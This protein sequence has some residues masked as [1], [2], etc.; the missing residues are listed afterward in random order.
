MV[1]CFLFI[2]VTQA[3]KNVFK[4]K[5]L[6]AT[7]KK[8][9]DSAIITVLVSGDTYFTNEKGEFEI[10]DLFHSSVIITQ[11]GYESL[12]VKL[13]KDVQTLYL[14]PSL[15]QLKEIVV[16]RSKNIN[17]IDVRNLTGSVVTVD[18]SKLSE[19]SELDMA[20]LLQGQVPG[21]TVNYSGEL[22][23]KPEIRLRGN[24]SF[25][26]KGTANEPLFV[27]DGIIISTETFLTL[28]PNDFSSI[29][30]LKDAPATA[31]YGIKA[32]NGVIE[33]TSKRGFNGKATI[34]YSMKQG[35][36]MRGERP[37]EMMGTNEKLA[38]EEKIGV[39]GRPGFDYSQANIRKLFANS[40]LLQQ[41]LE[42]GAFKLDSLR[43]Y[44]T[45]WFKEL[46][47]P[48]HFQ[49]HNLSIRGGTEKSAYFYSV[50]YSKQGGRIP[51]NDINHVT[52]RAN[53]DYTIAPTFQ[54]SLNNSFGVS[55]TNTENGMTNDPT[56]LAFNLNPYET[57]ETKQLISYPRQSYSDLINQFKEKT[58][59]KRFSSS[60]V[61][62]WDILKELNIAGV[63]GAD[64][65]I[66]E[67]YQRIYS[68]AFSQINKKENEKGFLSQSDT[69]NFSYS[70]NIRA[71]YQ[72][73]FGDHD[74]FLGFNVDYYLTD[75]KSINGSGHGISD[76]ISS[77]SGINSSFTNQFKPS[78]SGSK[79][80]NNQLGFGAAAGYTYQGIYDIYASLKRD[81]SSL[82]PSDKR[83][84][85]A[86]SAGLGWS[87]G[88]YE[89]FK[90]QKVLTS[91][92]FRTSIG[93]TASMTGILPRD[94]A[95]TYSNSNTFYGDYRVL[96]LAALPNKELQ[97]QQT[98][99]TNFSAD[100]GFIN[101]FNLLVS[102]YKNVTKEAILT[103][104][105]ATSNGFATYTKNIGELEN[106]GVEFTVNGDLLA[107]KTFRWNTAISISYNANKVKKLYGTDRI[108]TSNESVIPEY[109]V[110][111]PLGTLY[112]LQSN[113]IHPLI[114]LPE[115]I[116]NKG[117]VIDIKTNI[118]P[119]Y[120]S[121]LGS[122]IAPYNGY[123]NN[124]FTYKNWSLNVNVSYQLGGKAKFSDTYVRDESSS[125][126]NAIKGQL[127]DMW[128][129][130]GDE[131]KIYPIQKLP[132]Y[133]Y[134]YNS[135]P[136]SKTIYSTDY[137]K[138]NYIQ[139]SYRFT[140]N[141]FIDKYLRSLQIN[142]QADNLYT[143][144]IEK[145]R[146][147]LNDVIQPILTL[148]LNATF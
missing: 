62:H 7:T 126:K 135:F 83:W 103:L 121:K 109:E 28:N 21:L 99:S 96:Q 27:M 4:G 64:Y 51:G 80:K 85:D 79:V 1:L 134:S 129:E 30:V 82:L 56:E 58:T 118:T 12:E 81:G 40:P 15:I 37:A 22:G 69:K 59:N 57:K 60:V 44:N 23:K 18:M 46:I 24:S 2:G 77:L 3:Q 66:N 147:S 49:S 35:I 76:D 104:P 11:Q 72:K 144:R 78:A 32:A 70:A 124:Y 67:V 132:S 61:M 130:V 9:I 106:S 140:E 119:E 137:L 120:M 43:Q 128:F 146:G 45:D 41:K 87:P 94:I 16:R 102:L 93:Y 125:Y 122:T 38:F 54:L 138:L 98:Y 31:L 34:T 92:K 14:K 33:L 141:S 48:N 63:V 115:F 71:S 20:K 139:L 133:I 107:L 26:Y 73:K 47:K 117:N 42:Q 116:D 29:K 114:G 143:F 91:V 148:S 53:L 131:N 52:A 142:I 111:K 123:F 19:R 101:R 74:L 136:N 36:T 145:N 95:T 17:D 65:S 112:G 105:I 68:S 100:L 89:F 90:E 86:W 127:N 6:D 25:S 13:L 10:P 110:G 8:G 108:Y 75:I 39:A 97:P 50:N 88:Q 84:N 113:G 5:I 55:T